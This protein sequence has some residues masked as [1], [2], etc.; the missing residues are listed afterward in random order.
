MLKMTAAILFA[1]LLA[2]PPAAAQQPTVTA[3]VAP[4]ASC[5]PSNDGLS[6]ATPVCSIGVAVNILT[7]HPGSSVVQLAAGT[8]TGEGFDCR[9]PGGWHIIGDPANPSNVQFYGSTNLQTMTAR[10]NC[11]LM[12]DGMEFSEP[13]NGHNSQILQ[14][15]QL[16]VIDI[17]NVIFAQC[18][19]G[20]IIQV[21][22]GGYVNVSSGILLTANALSFAKTY[23]GGTISIFNPITI[24]HPI[25]VS[26]FF[27]IMGGFVI[28]SAGFGGPGAGSATS[29]VQYYVDG[30]GVMFRGGQVIPGSTAGSANPGYGQVF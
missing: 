29:G 21:N 24:T 17:Q 9:A 8:Y 1:L 5:N 11:I 26:R 12:I 15:D 6:P 20:P 18:L 10:D 23:A 2:S 4:P 30:F 13:S 27:D 28:V 16:G 3:Y 14:A 25:G 22:G 7:Q 19:N